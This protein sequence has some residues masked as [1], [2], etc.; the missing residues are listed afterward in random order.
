MINA[1]KTIAAIISARS[2][3]KEV[4]NKRIKG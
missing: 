1:I 2:V 3:S 4:K